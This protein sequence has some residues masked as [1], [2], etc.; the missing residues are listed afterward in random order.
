MKQIKELGLPS[1]SHAVPEPAACL[2]NAASGSD[3]GLSKGL[4]QTHQAQM[5]WWRSWTVEWLKGQAAAPW[6]ERQASKQPPVWLS[7]SW[8]HPRWPL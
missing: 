1:V 6:N 2:S 8:I 5:H 4:Q 3:E 7:H